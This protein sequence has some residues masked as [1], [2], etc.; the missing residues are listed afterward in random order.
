MLHIFIS[1]PIGGRIGQGSEWLFC[2]DSG[3]ETKRTSNMP[4]GTEKW[5]QSQAPNLTLLRFI[6]CSCTISVVTLSSTPDCS[7]LAGVSVSSWMCWGQASGLLVEV[8]V[9][10]DSW[11]HFLRPHL[12]WALALEPYTP[13]VESWL[14][15]FLVFKSFCKVGAAALPSGCCED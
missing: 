11:W 1:Y 13:G 14:C 7:T 12:L 3:A 10:K 8:F 5:K 6:Q 9:F 15:L 4:N 2:R